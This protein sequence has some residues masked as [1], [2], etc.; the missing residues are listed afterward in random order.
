VDT[1]V[2]VNP[3]AAELCGD[4]LDNDCDGQ[5]DDLTDPLAFTLWFADVDGDG[6]GDIASTVMACSAPTGFVSNNDDCDDADALVFPGQGCSI[7]CSEAEA[8]FIAQNQQQYLNDAVAAASNC[9]FQGGGLDEFCFQ[10]QMEQLGSPVSAG[11]NT[12]GY[13]F[14][15]CLL[16][17]CL[18]SCLG[19]F[20][21][22]CLQCMIDNG[23]MATFL[24]CVGANDADGDGYADQSDCAPSNPLVYPGAL[25]LCGDN[26]DNDCDGLV[27]E[28]AP[29]WFE[30]LDLDGFGSS[31]S[32]QSCTQPVGYVQVGGDCDD[33]DPNEFPGQ[34]CSGQECGFF[35]GV[36]QGTCGGTDVCVNGFCVPDC[37]DND[38]D[39]YT[40]CG[41]DCD[42]ASALINPDAVEI[43]DGVDNN[44]DGVVDEVCA[45][46]VGSVASCYSGPAGSDGIGA[47]QSGI[48]TCLAGGVWG[49]CSGEVLPNLE[50]CD[51]IDNNCNGVVDEGGVCSSIEV[52]DGID[53]DGDG[54]IDEGFDLLSDPMNCGGCGNV[55]AGVCVNGACQIT[56]APQG[57]PCDDGNACTV[58]EVQD[59]ACN[60]ISGMFLPA[61]STA[62]AQVAGDCQMLVCDGMGGIT[63]VVDNADVP[64]DGNDCTFDVCV[65]GM[66][67]NTPSPSGTPC[68]SGTCDGTGTCVQ[69]C[70]DNDLDSFTT[71]AGDCDDTNPM[72]FPGATEL[73]DGIDNDC[74]ASIDEGVGCSIPNGVGSCVFGLCT[75]SFC[76]AGFSDC[77]GIEANGCETNINTSVNNCGQCGDPCVLPNA[78]AACV[79]GQCTIA[80][81]LPGF[82]DCDG[83]AGNGCETFGTCP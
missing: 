60:C 13:Q 43:C 29:T 83:N 80:A 59:G 55:C 48:S 23:C 68:L 36:Q 50:V 21:G 28:N 53:N 47:C 81:C 3:G 26:L 27:D 37:Q 82:F 63:S 41:G 19:G 67:S 72:I 49:P 73:C 76:N 39:G 5:I 10:D 77:D 33:A 66:P 46:V 78:N 65:A 40:T 16:S 70:T 56:C 8:Q 1:D 32:Q 45:C 69:T 6:Y 11:C 42:D 51:G 74:D 58:G 54:Q 14:V 30:D 4:G 79:A 9:I 64:V 7:L 38:G 34:G 18:G 2:S 61:G 25:E 12:C 62:A 17:D 35:N 15:E 44:C 57:T 20:D 31:V 75:V 24:N 71:C 22:P 52:C